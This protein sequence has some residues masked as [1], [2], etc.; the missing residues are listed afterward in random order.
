MKDTSL[1]DCTKNI[2]DT[3]IGGLSIASVWALLVLCSVWL[4]WGDEKE[5]TSLSS[6]HCMVFCLNWVKENHLIL[7]NM[8]GFFSDP[9]L[10][11]KQGYYFMAKDLFYVSFSENFRS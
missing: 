6:L 8:W 1:N 7:L 11:P 9:F 2:R 10:L 5:Q 4:D 3:V